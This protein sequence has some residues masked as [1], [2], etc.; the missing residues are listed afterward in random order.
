MKFDQVDS[1]LKN[2]IGMPGNKGRRIYDFIINNDIK[3]VLELGFL[4]GKSTCYMAAALQEKG[5]GCVTTIDFDKAKEKTPD[6][7]SLS[8]GLRLDEHIKAV[9]TPVSYN[10]ELMKLIES[11][12]HDNQCVPLYDF[13]YI[14]GG[15]NWGTTGFG[16]FLV[17]KL[18]KKDGWILFDD[19]HWTLAESPS[20]KNKD[21]VK[22]M[23]EE[24]KT[25]PQVQKVFSLLA[26]QHPSFTDFKVEYNWGWARKFQ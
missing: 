25:T 6:I 4:H 7:L 22:D 3:Q 12:T 10:W 5:G 13:C 18:L 17:E 14:D 9:F 8:R 11:Q 21:S 20:L 16:F 24:F 23:P 26:K 1:E 15:H 19:L 2:I